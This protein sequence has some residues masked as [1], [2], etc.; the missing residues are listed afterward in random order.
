[1]N[2]GMDITLGGARLTVLQSLEVSH[3]F[4][5]GDVPDVPYRRGTLPPDCPSEQDNMLGQDNMPPEAAGTSYNPWVID[6]QDCTSAMS[7]HITPRTILP[8]EHVGHS[9]IV[10][11]RLTH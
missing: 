6:E 8:P 10:F 7:E 4:A 2:R 9:S 1:M 5:R 3:A 11:D